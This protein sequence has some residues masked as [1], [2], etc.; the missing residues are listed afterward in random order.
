MVAIDGAVE[1]TGADGPVPFLDLFQDR[2][3][4]VVYHSMWYD[5]APHQG[6]C[7]GCT[8]NLWHMKDAGY[9]NAR[10][11]SLAVVTS[12]SVERSGSVRRL[13]GLHRALVLGAGRGDTLCAEE[14]HSSVICAT[15]TARFLTYSTTG[16][17]NEPADGS[18]GL[19]DMTPYGRR[20]AWE[21][22]P[23]GGRG[24][25]GRLAGRWA[26]R[27]DLL[28][29]AL[30]RRRRRQLGPDQ[31]AGPAVDPPRRNPGGDPRPPARPPLTR[32]SVGQDVARPRSTWSGLLPKPI[33]R[34]LLS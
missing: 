2:D 7:E 9:L 21:N 34:G 10:G 20:E 13:H 15:A 4:L 18:L 11:V 12:G 26:W 23:E 29:L 14:G 28:V 31:P 5:G 19:L 17:G 32:G 16:R 27:A 24:P 8:F 30:G 6:Q 1:V 33:E 25:P 3:E 22:N